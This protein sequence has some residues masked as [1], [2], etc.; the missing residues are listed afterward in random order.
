MSWGLRQGQGFFSGE[1]KKG[2]YTVIFRVEVG[3]WRVSPQMF[4]PMQ[5]AFVVLG[6]MMCVNHRVSL[7]I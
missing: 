7:V 2:R 4:T 6:L 1:T 3:R 5:L